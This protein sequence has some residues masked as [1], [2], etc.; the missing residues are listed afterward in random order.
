MN[1]YTESSVMHYTSL[2]GI[3]CFNWS[4]AFVAIFF[5]D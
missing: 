1:K 4:N 2:D 3:I 5:Q